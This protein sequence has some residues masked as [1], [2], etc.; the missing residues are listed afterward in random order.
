MVTFY[1][2]HY[3]IGSQSRAS[4]WYSEI[5]MTP[6]FLR[7]LILA[8]GWP[9]LVMGSIFILVKTSKFYVAV[10]ESPF[11]KLVLSSIAGWLVTMYSLGIVSTFYMFS[12]LES[13]RIVFPIF[14]IW[15]VT[16]V[17][18]VTVT[19]RWSKEVVTLH[20]FYTGLEEE[21]RRRTH[22]L[23]KAHKHELENEKKIQRLKDE[24]LFIAAHELRSPVNAIKWGLQTVFEEKSATNLSPEIKE[25]LHSVYDR[26]ERLKDL[27]SRLLNTARLEQGVL[28]IKSERVEPSRIIREVLDE[29]AHTASENNIHLEN[30]AGDPP[31][32]L[33]DPTLL[34]EML[35]NLLTN[36]IRYN[37]KD[38]AVTITEKHTS[39]MVTI[40]V[41]D[42]GNGIPKQQL[43]HVFEKFHHIT[44]DNALGKDKSVGLGLYITKELATRMGGTI[45]ALSEE[46]K[47]STFSFSLPR[48]IS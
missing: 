39:R 38:G 40:S 4:L 31:A 34:K 21:V 45:T 36:A 29:V 13:V 41:R 43:P 32:I 15:F 42:T 17:I 11:G 7:T 3:T 20:A 30:N 33:A 27:I 44:H 23:E 14:L 6:E 48:D 22:E 19:I 2:H 35:T 8:T 1:T 18:I 28:T 5:I 12:S 37:K 16:F 9:V 10:K 26:N 47:G 25:I 46:G 24:F